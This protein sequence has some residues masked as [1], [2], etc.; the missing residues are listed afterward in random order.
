MLLLVAAMAKMVGLR[1]DPVADAGLLREPG[2]V[3][4]IIEWEIVLGLALLAGRFAAIVRWCTILTFL[5]FAVISLRSARA[6][7]AS[8]G[9]F[10]SVLINPWIVFGLDVAVLVCLV[11]CR[12]VVSQEGFPMHRATRIGVLAALFFAAVLSILTAVF[13]SL[14]QAISRLRGDEV[15][16]TPRTIDLGSQG[17][18]TSVTTEIGLTNLTDR[19]IRVA[20]GTSDC[21]CVAT[22]DLPFILAPGESR[23]VAVRLSLP[24]S[25]SGKFVRRAWFWTDAAERRI[26][27]WLTGYV[28]NSES[29]ATSESV[30]SPKRQ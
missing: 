14:P 22:D 24:A 12:P 17:A 7:W 2:F 25:A 6:G 20:G 21:R 8:C 15:S 11:V 10:G 29:Q 23:P 27:F 9:C 5:V 18:G 13:G 16:A 30:V 3:L 19:A 26:E 28:A 1:A 4:A